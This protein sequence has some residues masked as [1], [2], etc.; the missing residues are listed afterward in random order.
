MPQAF[1]DHEK[2]TIRHQMREKGKALFEKQGLKK[3]TV[4]ELTEIVGISKGAFYLF[5]DSKEDLYMEILEHLEIEIQSSIL[6]FSMQPGANAHH[7]VTDL[8]KSFFHTMEKAPILK[9]FNMSD[10]D[11]LVRKLPAE[12]VLQ[13]INSDDDFMGKFISKINREGIV[14][15]ASPN[16][17]SNLVKSLFL[18]GLHREDFKKEE[19]G[20]L[21]DVLIHLVAGYV[22]G[23]Y[24]ETRS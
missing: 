16:V 11:Y 21:M 12:R 5:Y 22:A 7:N 24:D 6:E 14:V 13:H 20:E 3:T 4:E 18:V 9:N 10:Y 17:I 15:D 23:E 2:E 8:L 19:Y 1:S